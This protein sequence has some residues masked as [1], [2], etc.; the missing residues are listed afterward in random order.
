[1]SETT[2]VRLSE[3]REALAQLKRDTARVVAS[4]QM[5]GERRKRRELA[6]ALEGC[7]RRGRQI[8]RIANELL[9]QAETF[10]REEREE[11]EGA[12]RFLT[13]LQDFQG[14]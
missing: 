1:M 6:R 13:Q 5:G 9:A 14:S 4:M 7:K 8:G 11:L 10:S 3:F 2:D 12:M